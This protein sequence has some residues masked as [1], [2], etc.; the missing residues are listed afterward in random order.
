M[1]IRMSMSLWR[2]TWRSISGAPKVW[3]WRPGQ[4]L[5][6]AGL[7]K[8][9]RHRGQRQALA[10]E[11]AHDHAEAR[12]LFAQAV[13]RGHAQAV[14]A[15]VRGVGAEPAHL[16]QRRAR[17]AFRVARHHDHGKAAGAFALQVCPDSERDPV[18][19][20]AGGDEHFF[21][22]DHV[23]VAIEPRGGAQAGHVGAATGLGDAERRDHLAA[24]HGRDHL[25][26]QGFAAV[27]EHG[28]QADVV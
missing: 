10:V 8:T 17:E 9:E 24:Q 11:V 19:A 26:L 15:Q 27:R 14:E 4:G 1:R 2:I 20:H 28:R 25:G 22:V 13:A 7:G 18:A 12:T 21:A 16:L 3:R 5:V 23:V 6:A